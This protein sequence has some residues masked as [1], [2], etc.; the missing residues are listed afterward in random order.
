MLQLSS[1]FEDKGPHVIR[2]IGNHVC[3]LADG[4]EVKVLYRCEGPQP[5]LKLLV[6][7]SS[8]RVCLGMGV[9]E[10]VMNSS[11]TLTNFT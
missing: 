11:I 1:Q 2:I 9:N 3:A 6:A 5:I 10:N 8:G 7:G 4:K